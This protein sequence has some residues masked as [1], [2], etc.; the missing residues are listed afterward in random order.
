MVCAAQPQNASA[1]KT[2]VQL[3]AI[4]AQRVEALNQTNRERLRSLGRQVTELMTQLA[5]SD[6]E[7]AQYLWGHVNDELPEMEKREMIIRIMVAGLHGLRIEQD[8]LD[9][10]RAYG[11]SGMHFDA[12]LFGDLMLHEDDGIP[13]FTTSEWYAILQNQLERPSICRSLLADHLLEAA[14]RK[15]WAPDGATN[16][17]QAVYQGQRDKQEIGQ[18][19]VD[20]ERRIWADKYVREVL[21][22]N[23]TAGPAPAV[24]SVQPQHGS[25]DDTYA[26]L[27]AI[28]V[29]RTDAANQTHRDA[30]R[31][32]AL[33]LRGVAVVESLP[34]DH[35]E[36][37]RYLM[38][39][40]NSELREIQKDQM[41]VRLMLSE[42]RK[43]RRKIQHETDSNETTGKAK[44]LNPDAFR[45]VA[46][47][48]NRPDAGQF[49]AVLFAHLIRQE[50]DGV[51]VFTTPEW[52][53]VLQ[54]QL[55]FP[56]IQ[57]NLI[58]QHLLETAQRQGSAPDDAANWLQADP[59]Q[60]YEKLK[61]ARGLLELTTGKEQTWA[62]VGGTNWSELEYHAD[63]EELKIAQE[64]E[65][66]QRLIWA[67]KFL[68]EEMHK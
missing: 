21:L 66:A 39:H 48:L 62:S 30:E 8:Q 37:A 3:Q 57:R 32:K 9:A 1:D 51:P 24:P 27:R 28:A 22:T 50:N 47:F 4:A 20:A 52:G 63:N 55:E 65:A 59:H 49:E 7:K 58:T 25:A 31:V 64:T 67:R 16:W 43:L 46:A 14:Q 44:V 41:A 56:S 11:S 17:L 42:A 29:E 53:A 54:K 19:A 23:R 33:F 5:G 12:F 10:F 18:A 45:T 34:L 40:I 68:W 35:G 38:G 61:A 15:G 13:V 26:Q 36:K 6:E 60:R 2:Y